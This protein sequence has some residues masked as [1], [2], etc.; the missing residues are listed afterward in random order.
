MK[1]AA[2]QVESLLENPGPNLRAALLYGPDQGLVRER[3]DRIARSIVQDFSDP[4]RISDL[5]VANIKDSP[6]R[7]LDEAAALSMTSGARIVRVRGVT[8]EQAPLFSALL[9]VEQQLS[10]VIAEAGELRSRSPLRILFEKFEHAAAI[11]CYLDDA[12][13]IDH[14]IDE[15]CQAHNLTI[16]PDARR[17]LLNNLGSDRLVSRSELD[18]L[19]LYLGE[20]HQIT[21]SVVSAIVGDNGEATLNGFAMAVA[22]GNHRQASRALSRLRLE[23]MTPIQAIRGI[24]RHLHRVHLVTTLVASGESIGRAV[25]SLRPSVHFSDNKA[26]QR[27]ALAWPAEKLRRAMNILLDAETECK[28]RSNIATVIANMAFLRVINAARQLK[29]R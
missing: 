7:L 23:G 15:I 18:K 26:F 2:R 14:L 25:S 11:A 24:L 5:S 20:S 28:S 16:T 22:G 27:Q 10:L 17:Y 3:A 4:F 29:I 12:S 8:D 13:G 9:D 6:D 21:V 1:I 19:A